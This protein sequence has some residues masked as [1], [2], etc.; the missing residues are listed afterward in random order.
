MKK[1]ILNGEQRQEIYFDTLYGSKLRL[2]L[3]WLR[4]KREISKTKFFR[5]ILKLND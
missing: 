3:A 5:I 2:N 4:F 1:P